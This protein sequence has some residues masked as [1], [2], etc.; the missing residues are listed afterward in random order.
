MADFYSQATLT[1]GVRLTKA[2]RH[3]IGLTNGSY[4]VE[5]KGSLLEDVA[6]G[7]EDSNTVYYVYWED[8]FSTPDEGEVEERI[9][10]G[11]FPEGTPEAAEFRRLAKLVI[12]D[13]TEHFLREVLLHNPEV[14][15]LELHKSYTCSKMRDDGFGGEGIYVTRKQFGIVCDKSLVVDE[16]TD[17]IHLVGDLVH[18]F[19]P[20]KKTKKSKSAPRLLTGREADLILA[21]LRRFQVELEEDNLNCEEEEIATNGDKWPMPTPK[22]IDKLCD[23]LNSGKIEVEAD[24]LLEKIAQA[25]RDPKEKKSC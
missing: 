24:N 21:A 2:M 7:E 20:P 3:V 6:A 25:A 13:K 1:P 9:G 18:D 8:G 17:T 12:E 4:E 11:D 22:F 5:S 14:K 16:K 15:H 19:E 10:A 23:A